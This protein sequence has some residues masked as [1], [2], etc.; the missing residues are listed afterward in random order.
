MVPN[1]PPHTHTPAF[2]LKHTGKN[3]ILLDPNYP[4]ITKRLVQ[5][6][7]VEGGKD[8][9]ARVALREEDPQLHCQQGHRFL[10]A[11]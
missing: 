3:N 2:A 5:G 10:T 7:K 4:K 1:Q 8:L 9:I 6:W 11:K